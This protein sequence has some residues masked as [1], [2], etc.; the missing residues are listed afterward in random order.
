MMMRACNI[1]GLMVVGLLAVVISSTNAGMAGAWEAPSTWSDISTVDNWVA[2]DAHFYRIHEESLYLNEAHDNINQVKVYEQ[3][4]EYRG[5]LAGIG[6]DKW[7]T[8]SAEEQAE[9]RKLAGKELKFLA[10]FRNRIINQVQNTRL[11]LRS[12]W[13]QQITDHTV[14]GDALAKLRTAVALDPSNP[15]AWHLYSYFAT[16][17]GDETR[18]LTAIAGA[19]TALAL[20]PETEELELRT[21]VAVDKAWLLRSQGEFS[22][23]QASLEVAGTTGVKSLKGRLLQGLLAAQ[24]GDDQTAITIAVELR[25]T[26]VSRFPMNARTAGFRPDLVNVDAWAQTPSSY[27]HDWIMAYTWLRVG[28]VELASS[29]FGAHRLNDQRQFAT[30]FWDE[31]AAFYEV[32]GRNSM[33]QNAWLQARVTT[34]YYPYMVSK[35]Y[36]ERL[37]NL[38][39]RPGHIPYL[40]GFDANFL[41]GSRL[42][43]SAALVNEMAAATEP[44]EKMKLATRALDQLEI[45]EKFGVYAGPASVLQGQV[46]YLMGDLSSALAEI[47]Q[48]LEILQKNGDTV[49]YQAVLAQLSVVDHDLAPQDIANFY[50]QSGTSRGRWRT[51]EDPAAALTKLRDTYASQTN[52]LNRQNLARFLIRSGELDEGRELARA[53]LGGGVVTADNV[54]ELSIGDVELLLEAERA[55][56]E[57]ALA[58]HMVA[59][60]KSGADNPWP[61]ANVW[62]L[63]GFICLDENFVADGKLALQRASVLD[64]G[65][66]GLKI[67]LSLM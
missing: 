13:G 40:L 53:S 51:D 29:A 63:V 11:E 64:P 21:A 34:P 18:A 28:E 3:T 17:V 45:C 42:A 55:A 38:T 41:S 47:E 35:D 62:A 49:G 19:E 25:A 44:G 39:G 59:T 52:D 6:T 57:S 61:R 30:R 31:A 16:L 56:G 32:T 1:K 60:L 26:K 14:V 33:A 15:Y 8:L 10:D 48:A 65:N 9:R 23:A 37:G 58:S 43:Y 22:E 24:M 50:G 36:T 5:R 27:L 12:G 7:Q 67:Q 2:L 66:Q 46:Y 20:I 54:T 4:R